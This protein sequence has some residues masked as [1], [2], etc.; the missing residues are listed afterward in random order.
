M[1]AYR[2]AALP[3]APDRCGVFL[4]KQNW[5][6]AT[7]RNSCSPGGLIQ[8]DGGGT[9]VD[10]LLQLVRHGGARECDLKGDEATEIQRRE[11]LVEGLHPVLGLTGLHHAVDLMDLVLADQVANG[12]VRE[13]DLHRH[14]AAATGGFWQQGLTENALYHEGE[15]HS[16]AVLPFVDMSPERDQTYFCEGIAEEGKNG[17]QETYTFGQMKTLTNRFANVLKSLGIQ[18]GDRVFLFMD[19]LPELY[20]AFFGILKA[21]AIAGPLC[22]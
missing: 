10:D 20:I 17:E 8:S 3:S 5:A 12:G 14:D 16:I 2:R 7:S 15:L 11:R 19:R 9:A 13:Q 1:S 4:S 6:W 18:K 21:G 22:T